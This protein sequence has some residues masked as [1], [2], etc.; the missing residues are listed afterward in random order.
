MVKRAK[1]GVP[2]GDPVVVGW[3]VGEQGLERQFLFEDFAAA[4]KFVQKVGR[5][6]EKACH[7]PDIDIRWNRVTLRLISH[8]EGRVTER[9]VVLASRFSE[10]VERPSGGRVRRRAG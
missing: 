3:E 2:G 10:I 4:M 7:H 8:D 1:T 6:A 5:E 9:D